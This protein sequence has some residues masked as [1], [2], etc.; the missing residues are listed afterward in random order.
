M[1]FEPWTYQRGALVTVKETP[2]HNTSRSTLLFHVVIGTLWPGFHMASRDAPRKTIPDY[3]SVGVL[4]ASAA[5]F[6]ARFAVSNS[7]VTAESSRWSAS[8]FAASW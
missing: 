6:Q 1:G 2:L 7:E 3:A 5:L 8:G 4:S